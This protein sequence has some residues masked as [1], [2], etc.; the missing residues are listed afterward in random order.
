MGE[1]ACYKH[2]F[3]NVALY[4]TLGTEAVIFIMHQTEMA[5]IL[6][7]ADK[8][9]RILSLKSQL[10][11]VK[12]FISMDD[13]WD[14]SVKSKA[15]EVGVQIISF[16]DVEKLGKDEPKDNVRLS[17]SEDIATICYTR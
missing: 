9:S 12:Y 15:E 6:G 3:I 14:E 13:E 4:D 2:G 11:N 16:R 17:L 8:I 7:S 1:Q 10:P 5:Y